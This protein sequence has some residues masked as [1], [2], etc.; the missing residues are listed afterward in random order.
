MS[1]LIWNIRGLGNHLALQYLKDMINRH[2]PLIVGILEPK[3]RHSKIGDY[4]Q[5]IGLPNFA[6]AEPANNHIWV[7]WPHG[8]DITVLDVSDQHLSVLLGGED[9]IKFSFVYAKCLRYERQALW[10]QLRLHSDIDIPWLVGGDFNTILRVSEKR[11]GLDPDM[12]SIQ[13]FRECLV[14]NNLSE[15]AYTGNEFTWCNN[16]SGNRRIWQ[17]LDRVLGNGMSNTQLPELTVQHLT[18]YISDHSP[19]LLTVASPIPYRSRFTFQRMWLD[20]PEFHKL[21]EDIWNGSVVGTPSLRVAEKL[22]RLKLKLKSW[23][24][25][26]FG[27][28]GVQSRQLQSRVEELD[29]RLQNRWSQELEDEFTECNGQLRQVNAWET[30]LTF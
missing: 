3:Q 21:V 22:K 13:D 17:R 28:V 7:F 30:E 27:D 2:Q 5:Q 20:H 18:R 9:P 23:N 26:T 8:V 25:E 12:G 24:W 29:T 19:L 16:K 11:G 10:D 6:H 14:E 4:A 1:V 15:V